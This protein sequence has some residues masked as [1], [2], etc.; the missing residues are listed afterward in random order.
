MSAE[1]KAPLQTLI[2][3]KKTTDFQNI[4]KL[5]QRYKPVSWLIFN[6]IQN[7]KNC[8]R[9]GWTLS[10]KVGSAVIRNKLKRWTR[11]CFKKALVEKELNNLGIDLNL[12]F[13]QRD[14]GFYRN[15]K[16]RDFEFIFQKGISRIEKLGKF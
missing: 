5:G 15:L 7:E 16:Y 8:F 2:V 1:N 12:V 4:Q 11:V 10:R 6:F 14:D 13:L 3:L 9:C